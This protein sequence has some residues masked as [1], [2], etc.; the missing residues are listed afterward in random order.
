M[1]EANA[2]KTRAESVLVSAPLKLTSVEKDR[3]RQHKIK[4][5]HVA[6]ILLHW[7]NAAVWFFMLLTGA[8]LLVSDHYKVMPRFML[9]ILD[10]LFSGRANMLKFHIW[11]GVLWAIV[12]AG[13][14]IFGYRSYVRRK[15]IGEI[16]IADKGWK[17]RI[18]A[19]QCMLFGNDALCLDIDD[20]RWLKIRFLRIIE[21]SDE[22][23]PPQGAFNAGQKLF[24]LIAALMTPVIM[25]TGLIM[26]FHLMGTTAVAWSAPLHF[27]A[28]GVVVAGLMVHV[29][30][31]AVFP[32]EKPAFFSMITGFVDELFAYTHHFKWWKA[33]VK[34][35]VK[36]RRDHD[37]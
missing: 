14:A 6:T 17:S 24:G 34:E 28:V 11:L 18:K 23:L 8:G 35:E 37:G 2:A 36:W 31:G 12:F 13:H 16:P 5:H 10:G 22:P 30:M 15:R 3:L 25:I 27:L 33:M 19:I 20:L 29:Y 21:K 7:F 1:P 9:D 4:K 32:E 26:A